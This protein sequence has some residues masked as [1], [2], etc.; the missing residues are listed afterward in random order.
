MKNGRKTIIVS[1]DQ[2]SV[3]IFSEF[4]AMKLKCHTIN[5]Q[6]AS[7]ALREFSDDID[8]LAVDMKLTKMS[9]L[10]FLSTI[11]KKYPKTTGILLVDEGDRIDPLQAV[12]EA[13][14][15]YI[16]KKPLS[17]D[18]LSD[19]FKKIGFY[20][21]D[22]KD[23]TSGRKR[24]DGMQ[25]LVRVIRALSHEIKA[26]LAIIHAN[27]DM[28][29]W[30][31]IDENK[32]S[33]LFK[34]LIRQSNKILN[35][36]DETSS[37]AKGKWNPDLKLT[38]MDAA[39]FLSDLICP[40]IQSA[41]NRGIEILHNNDFTGCIMLDIDQ[42]RRVL[43]NLLTNSIEAGGRNTVVCIRIE[44][45]GEYLALRFQDNGPGVP[46]GE[47]ETIFE[48]FVSIS[49]RRGLGLG[50]TICRGII[51]SHGGDIRS[52]NASEGG[53]V[54]VIKLPVCRS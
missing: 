22:E 46:A 44:N 51:R 35:L 41:E 48:P 34:N 28:L 19:G 43:D 6:L 50:L 13:G 7:E 27:A 39:V 9:A 18:L 24:E 53:A 37:I 8:I 30:E 17:I 26:P 20:P 15:S 49:G 40:F 21:I 47:E 10:D 14:L 12:N 4:M 42:M 2:P 54:F 11:H 16:F 5:C 29:N 1:V 33:D 38:R 32:R 45:D 25:T 31:N 36:I 3:R 23:E 52:S